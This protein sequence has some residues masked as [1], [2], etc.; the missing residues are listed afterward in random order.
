MNRYIINKYIN[1]PF[2]V[3]ILIY[4]KIN[5]KHSNKDKFRLLNRQIIFNRKIKG[6][7]IIFKKIIYSYFKK[8]KTISMKMKLLKILNY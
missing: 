6:K 3:L 8:I 1:S 4:N 2:L 7:M 5:T